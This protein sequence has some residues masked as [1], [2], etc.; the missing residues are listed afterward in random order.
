MVKELNMILV[1]CL[2]L[3]CEETVPPHELSH[4]LVGRLS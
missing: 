4:N 2:G 1:G 3:Y